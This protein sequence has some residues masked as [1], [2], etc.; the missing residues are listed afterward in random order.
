MDLRNG[1]VGK[2]NALE[3][4]GFTNGMDVP[5]LD[6]RALAELQGENGL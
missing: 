3:L 4:L 1:M 5:E 6:E 2:L